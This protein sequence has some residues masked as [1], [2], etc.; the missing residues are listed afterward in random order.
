MHDD[1]MLGIL[2]HAVTAGGGGR[3][4]R[5]GRVVVNDREGWLAGY[6]LNGP[7]IILAEQ[8]I[9]HV[10]T[11]NHVMPFLAAGHWWVSCSASLTCQKRGSF[12]W[13][14]D[15]RGSGRRQGDHALNA[16]ARWSC[17]ACAR[18]WRRRGALGFVLCL[19]T[20]GCGTGTGQAQQSACLSGPILISSA[21]GSTVVLSAC[22][23]AV[24]SRSLSPSD[25]GARARQ[26]A[27]FRFVVAETPGQGKAV[28]HGPVQFRVE[29]VT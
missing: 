8:Q 17:S 22:P 23:A 14:L 21:K 9:L 11:N 27:S 28:H 4:K 7:N 18:W 20:V 15:R 24:S 29:A 6:P 12:A 5:K 16:G 3:V 26:A 13:S 25:G 19:C 10:A 2:P 1:M